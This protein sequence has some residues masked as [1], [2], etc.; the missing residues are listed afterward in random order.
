MTDTGTLSVVAAGE[1]ETVVTR[2]FDAPRTKVFDAWTKPEL[3]ALWYGPRGWT[4]AVCE[5]DLKVGGAWNFVMRRAN[6]TEFGMRGVY[7]AVNDSVVGSGAMLRPA[8][9][10]VF[11][12]RSE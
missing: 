12:T 3:L 10:T 5:V 11:A 2:T 8:R 9:S 1:R 6:G 4:L 7:R